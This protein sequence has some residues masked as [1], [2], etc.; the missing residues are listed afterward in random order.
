MREINPRRDEI[1][2]VSENRARRVERLEKRPTEAETQ[3]QNGDGGKAASLKNAERMRG[4]VEKGEE[5]GVE[6]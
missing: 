2:C 5:D 4:A 3:G 6:V 1:Q